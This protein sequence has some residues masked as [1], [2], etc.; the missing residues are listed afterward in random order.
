MHLLFSFFNYCY[1]QTSA[2][3]SSNWLRLENPLLVCMVG[4][5]STRRKSRFKIMCSLTFKV[6]VLWTKQNFLSQP[7]K[8]NPP[9]PASSRHESFERREGGASIA[10]TFTKDVYIMLG[11]SYIYFSQPEFSDNILMGRGGSCTWTNHDEQ[12]KIH[13]QRLS[14]SRV[15]CT[16]HSPTPI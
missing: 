9:A 16:C 10:Q 14:A 5:L 3:S 2:S 7:I 8:F 11:L 12:H 1:K 4:G 6:K 13:Q 15:H